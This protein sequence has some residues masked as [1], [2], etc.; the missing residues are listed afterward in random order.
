[1]GSASRLETEYRIDA[2]DFG[3]PEA[4]LDMDL[5]DQAYAD[6]GWRVIRLTSS[7]LDA[8]RTGIRMVAATLR[9][10]RWGDAAAGGG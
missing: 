7:P 6:A 8:A 1:M 5:R 10:R 3:L 4:E 9:G 2:A